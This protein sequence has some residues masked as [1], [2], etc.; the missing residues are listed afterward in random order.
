MSGRRDFLKMF[1]LTAAAISGDAAGS[2]VEVRDPSIRP[3]SE[4]FQAELSRW[5]DIQ[6]G[7]LYSSQTLPAGQLPQSIPFFNYAVGEL[8]DGR[9]ETMAETNMRTRNAMPPPSVFCIE[10]VG[11]VFDPETSKADRDVIARNFAFNLYLGEKRYF[12]RPVAS[13]FETAAL[14]PHPDKARAIIGGVD[15]NPLPLILQNQQAF[16]VSI[17]CHGEGLEIDHPV[18]LWAFFEGQHARG[19]Q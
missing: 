11:I 19:V 16:F 8:R 5:L 13:M 6:K 2:T 4:K 15:L 3:H 18:K 10:K 9:F 1:G 12:E 14:N 17:D 7:W